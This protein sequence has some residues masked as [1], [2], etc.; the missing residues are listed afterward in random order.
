MPPTGYVEVNVGMSPAQLRGL[1]TSYQTRLKHGDISSAGPHKIFVPA[2]TAQKMER[3]VLKGKGMALKLS[4][5][6]HKYNCRHGAGFMDFL[7]GAARGVGKVGKAVVKT[8]YKLGK[9][10]APIALPA[11]GAAVGGPMGALIANQLGQQTGLIET[12]GAEMAEEEPTIDG[13]GVWRS[14]FEFPNYPKGIMRNPLQRADDGTFRGC[15]DGYVQQ[16]FCAKLPAKSTRAWKMQLGK[17]DAAKQRAAKRKQAS[18]EEQ[19]WAEHEQKEDDF[20]DAEEIVNEEFF[21][22]QDHGDDA[23]FAVEEK[24][25]EPPRKKAKKPK[26]PKTAV[27]QQGLRRSTRERK[28][29][30]DNYGGKGKRG[31]AFIG[32]DGTI[33]NGATPEA[34]DEWEM[35][36]TGGPLKR[37]IIGMPAPKL[38]GPSEANQK[39]IDSYW[40]KKRP[41]WNKGNP[42]WLSTTPAAKARVKGEKIEGGAIAYQTVI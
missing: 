42:F 4:S 15:P 11:V 38:P 36:Q 17:K 39:M 35:Q 3:A 12:P 24:K 28:Q 10:L 2:R 21:D 20:D 29:A 34:I 19:M 23:D 25:E 27:K 13:G 18:E 5:A 1:A 6:C 32:A 9:T 22:A 7:R 40:A 37:R 8:G 26:K 14:R 16:T 30:T 33:Q 31:G 41:G